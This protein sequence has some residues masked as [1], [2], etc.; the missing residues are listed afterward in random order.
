[1]SH[2]PHRVRAVVVAHTPGGNGHLGPVGTMT[3]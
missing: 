1:M 2:V 3:A